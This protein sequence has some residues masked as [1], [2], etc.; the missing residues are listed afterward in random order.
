MPF[1]MGRRRRAVMPV[2]VVAV[3]PVGV[4]EDGITGMMPLKERTSVAK[5]IAINVK[6][7]FLGSI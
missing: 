1:S 4:T 6:G 2:T 3:A 5:I 7:Q